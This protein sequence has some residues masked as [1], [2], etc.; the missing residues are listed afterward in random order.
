MY[1]DLVGLN[2]HTAPIAIREKLALSIINADELWQQLRSRNASG[3]VLST[4]NRTEVYISTD[5]AGDAKKTI[6][7]FL[8][9]YLR[10]GE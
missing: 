3:I 10:T 9:S 6:F 5:Q 8:N 1:I 2:H 7:D 4:C